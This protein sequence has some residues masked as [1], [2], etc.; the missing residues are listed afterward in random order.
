ML[1]DMD[2]ENTTLSGPERRRAPSNVY[3]LILYAKVPFRFDGLQ[4]LRLRD[5]ANYLAIFPRSLG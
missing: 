5:V 4:I 1:K 2:N 3:Y